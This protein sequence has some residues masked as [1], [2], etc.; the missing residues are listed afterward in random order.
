V[1]TL[2]PNS[3]STTTSLTAICRSLVTLTIAPAFLTASIYLCL[4]RIVVVVGAD[5]S[6]IKPRTYSLLFMACDFLSLLLQAAGGAIASGANTKSTSDLGVN[7]M[8][9]GLSFQVISLALFMSLCLE[10]AWRVSRAS[11]TKRNPNFARLRAS[12]KFKAF[13]YCNFLFRLLFLS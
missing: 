10:F 13:L 2:N 7:I 11:S 12:F 1:R 8:I 5:L 9:A 4:A 6:R 3:S